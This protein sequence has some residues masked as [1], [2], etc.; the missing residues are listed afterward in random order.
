[1]TGADLVVGTSAGAAVAAQIGSGLALDALFARQTDPALQAREISVTLDAEQMAAD[2]AELMT[3][4]TSA[5]DMQ[6]RIGAYALKAQTVPAAHRRAAIATRLPARDWPARRIQL[7][8]VDAETGATRVFDRESGASLLDAVAAICA[9]PGIWP[10][11][12]IDGRHYVDG[13]IR[14]ADNADL[15]S[16]YGRITV[17]SP[18]GFDPPFPSPMPPLRGRRRPSLPRRGGD[19]DHAGRSVP[20]RHERQ[21][22]RP[23]DQDAGRA[24]GPGAGQGRAA[25]SRSGTLRRL[26]DPAAVRPAQRRQPERP[27]PERPDSCSY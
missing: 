27:L 21:P 14:S 25:R 12:E 13:G 26:A 1:V 24:R 5:E 23:G 6:Q 17:V 16:G 20:G 11:V 4:V 3:G 9:V 10:P 8:A 2:F 18:L 15:A 19:C 22:A 7:V